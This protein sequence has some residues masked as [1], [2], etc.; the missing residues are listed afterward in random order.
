MPNANDNSNICSNN[1]YLCAKVSERSCD[2]IQSFFFFALFLLKT[3]FPSTSGIHSDEKC[4]C[5]RNFQV[6]CEQNEKTEINLYPYISM[7][8]IHPPRNN[9]YDKECSN[10]GHN[11]EFSWVFSNILEKTWTKSMSKAIILY[12]SLSS[13]STKNSFRIYFLKCPKYIPKVMQ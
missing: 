2:A 7:E 5:H 3:D 12:E 4:T 10:L 9:A 13:I 11:T 1:V 8:C 6:Y